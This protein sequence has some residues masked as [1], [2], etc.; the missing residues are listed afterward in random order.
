MKNQKIIRSLVFVALLVI[1]CAATGFAQNKTLLK[2]TTYKTEKLDFG[3]GG[4]VSIIGAPEGSISVEGWSKMEVEVSAEIEVQ[5]E[6]ESD[7]ARLAAISN[8]VLDDTLGHVRIISVG[9]Y[10]KQHLKKAAKKFPKNLLGMPLRIDYKIKVP[11][12]CDLEID[13]GNGDFTLAGI[14]GSMKIKFLNSNAKL[15]LV[16]GMLNATFG[17]GTVDVSVPSRSWRGRFADVQLAKGAMNVW[18]PLSLNAEINASILRT[19]EIENLLK[20]LKPRERK[21]QFTDK[22]IVAKAG[23]G[24]VSLNFTVGDGNLKL[25]ELKKPD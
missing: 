23:T 8:F 5:A 2:R 17:E 24:G 7:L 14:E 16:G 20:E 3:A 18:L 11:V 15:A 9:A 22:S 1:V 25:S 13:G 10:D 19:G 21:T 4:T 12:Y 6:T